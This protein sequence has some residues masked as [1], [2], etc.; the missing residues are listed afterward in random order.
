MKNSLLISM[1]LFTSALFSQ[2]TGVVKGAIT[3]QLLDQEP[4]VMATVQIIGEETIAQTNFHGNYE[5]DNLKPGEYT[6]VFS[7]L[8]YEDKKT[9]ITIKE[10]TIASID[11]ALAPIQISFEDVLN[12]DS[13]SN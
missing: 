12:M 3:D 8:G 9:T 11:M 6:L 7:Y 4:L 5:L 13:A 1:F 2:N 10:N